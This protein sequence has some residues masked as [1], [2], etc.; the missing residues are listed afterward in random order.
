MKLRRISLSALALC[1]IA[2]PAMAQ[3]IYSNGAISGTIDAWTI[4]FGFVVSDT[5]TVGGSGGTVTGLSFG[6]WEDPGDVLLSA[7]V[8]ITSA[9]DGGTVFFDQVANFTQSGCSANQYGFNVC[10]E[11]GSLNPVNLAAGTYWINLDNAV[12]EFGSPIFWDENDGPSL[13]SQTSVG[14]IPSESFTVLG[15][16]TTGGGSVPEPGSIMLFGTGILGLAGFLRR[17]LF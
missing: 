8:Q 14:T 13:A 15:T 11:T 2:V 12:T 5:F 16:S 1:L 17:K 4:N 7:E 3:T 9:E 10:T 6:V